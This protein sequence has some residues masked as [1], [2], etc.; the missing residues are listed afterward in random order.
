MYKWL[1]NIKIVRFGNLYA[2]RRGW[3]FYEYKDISV[4]GRDLWLEPESKWFESC[5]LGTLTAAK[6]QYLRL[7]TPGEVISKEEFDNAP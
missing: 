4:T 1:L 7:A 6:R 2:V 5:C 3:V